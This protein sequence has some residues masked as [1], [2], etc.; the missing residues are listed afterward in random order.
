MA[1]IFN[2]YEELKAAQADSDKQ[3]TEMHAA[4][5]GQ[6]SSDMAVRYS[7]YCP[8]Q[9]LLLGGGKRYSL[10]NYQSRK[11]RMRNT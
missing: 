11:M 1:Q 10:K 2:S 4:K 5:I 9:L 3:V 8:K 6:V 7:E